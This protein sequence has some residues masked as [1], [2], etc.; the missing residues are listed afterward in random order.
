MG[1]SQIRGPVGSLRVPEQRRGGKEL[2]FLSMPLTR[3]PCP[4]PALLSCLRLQGHE[5]QSTGCSWTP[6]LEPRHPPHCVA[7]SFLT[8]GLVW[9][10]GEEPP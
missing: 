7:R 4:G 8:L 1:S 3:F 10:R 6:G 5:A 9:E 2:G